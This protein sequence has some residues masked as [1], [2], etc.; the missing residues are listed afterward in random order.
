MLSVVELGL[1][2][3]VSHL[4][5]PADFMLPQEVAAVTGCSV[6]DPRGQGLFLPRLQ[7]FAASA[8]RKGTL[9]PS[10]PWG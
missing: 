5:T 2:F 4:Q 3:V 6:W 8:P 1:A 9:R 10:P 7:L